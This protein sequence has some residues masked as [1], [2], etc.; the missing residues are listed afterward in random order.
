MGRLT[1]NV[2]RAGARDRRRRRVPHQAD[3]EAPYHPVA[4]CITT[5][6]RWQQRQWQYGVA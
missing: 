3:L 4:A 1:M 5:N 2:R 6:Y